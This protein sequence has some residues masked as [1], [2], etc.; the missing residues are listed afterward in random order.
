MSASPNVPSRDGQSLL[1][2]NAGS[3]SIKF[4]LFTADEALVRVFEGSVEG[5]GSAHG[6]FGVKG[7]APA[8]TIARHFALPDSISAIQVLMDWLGN[9]L[10]GRELAAIGHRVVHGGP[11]Y[12][13]T[14]PVTTGMMTALRE[15]ASYDPEHLPQESLIIDALR[16][17]FPDVP[18]IACFDTAFHHAMPRVARILPIP[19]RY[20]AL[21]VRRYGFHGLSCAFLIGELERLAGKEVSNGRV[22]LAHL[23]GGASV[24]A[25][26]NGQSIDTSMGMTPGGG[27]PMASRSGDLDPG[28]GWYLSR[29]QQLTPA[30]F[31]HMVT[32]ESGL[33]GVS[34]TS[35]DMRVLLARQG[36]DSR[37]AEAVALFCYQVRKTICAMASSL[38]GLDTLVF[39]GGIGEHA[40]AVRER[41]CDGLGFVGVKFDP[42][43]NDAHGAV[44][45]AHSSRVCVR[46]IHTD[47]QWMIAAQMRALLR[48]EAPLPGEQGT[49]Q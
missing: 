27:V 49:G 46:V 1:T 18:H 38:Q 43:K 19:R 11:D 34:E 47:E 41:I 42:E 8:D 7:A 15:F 33:L 26:L 23:G 31:N 4:A 17:R 28:L 14:Q 20:E 10:D 24:T 22:V 2:I 6:A 30:K 5:I 45:S 3:S 44:I 48:R 36:A 12:W 9:R 16:R 13:Q 29:T 39:S 25:V 37:A 21:G 40:A 35:G 32:H